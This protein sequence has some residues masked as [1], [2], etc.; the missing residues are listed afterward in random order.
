MAKTKHTTGIQIGHESASRT[1][2]AVAAGIVNIFKAGRETS[3]DQSTILAAISAFKDSTSINGVS[4][5]GC[6]IGL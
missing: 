2:E 5:S 1:V 4:V 3:M 6:H